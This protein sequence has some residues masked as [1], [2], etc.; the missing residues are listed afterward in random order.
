M[1]A[2]GLVHPLEAT[3]LL[4]WPRL[5]VRHSTGYTLLLFPTGRM[6]LH[7]PSTMLKHFPHKAL[8]TLDRVPRA[9]GSKLLISKPYCQPR[10]RGY[11]HCWQYRGRCRLDADRPWIFG[12]EVLQWG[13]GRLFCVFP[14]GRAGSCCADIDLILADRSP[15]YRMRTYNPWKLKPNPL[16]DPE[17]ISLNGEAVDALKNYSLLP[18][19]KV[20]Y[21]CQGSCSG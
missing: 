5:D 2:S 17:L 8:S 1:S 10:S 16:L 4:R 6:S 15:A 13:M 11:S 19:G 3:H 21:L 14:T 20:W 9:R 18:P 12:R 7:N